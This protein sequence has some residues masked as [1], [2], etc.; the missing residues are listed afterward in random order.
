M[1]FDEDIFDEIDRLFKEEMRKIRKMITELTRINPDEIR[2]FGRK[3]EPIVFGFT[4]RWHSGMNKPEVKFF[5]NVRPA[6]PYG[7]KV[8][9]A[10]SP[11]Y[12]I[13]DKGDHYEIVVE[14]A[15]ARKEDVKLE[16]KGRTIYITAN[17]QYKKYSANIQIPPD[18]STEDIKAKMNNGI[19]II[20]IPKVESKGEKRI[21]IE[22]D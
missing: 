10:V 4:Y 9:D 17:T 21:E 8:D 11:V 15:G 1:V 12:D 2:E 16:M 6:S 13:L 14:L 18:A 5:G 22:E 3:G 20:N 19:L 7:I